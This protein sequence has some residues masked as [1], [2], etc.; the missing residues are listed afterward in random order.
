MKG[1]PKDFTKNSKKM[2]GIPKELEGIQWNS[3]G[4]YGIQ[5]ISKEPKEPM[6]GRDAKTHV[7]GSQRYTTYDTLPPSPNHKS[8]RRQLLGIQDI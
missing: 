1:I 8:C 5:W 6:W 4:V 7:R 3:N 2:K